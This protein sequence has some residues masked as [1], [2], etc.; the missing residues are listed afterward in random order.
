MKVGCSP[1]G[2]SGGRA[3]ALAGNDANRMLVNSN[4]P[5]F[6]T[7]LTDSSFRNFNAIHKV[8]EKT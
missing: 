6:K 7:Q 8:K 2:D 5:P 4:A 1:D 3:C